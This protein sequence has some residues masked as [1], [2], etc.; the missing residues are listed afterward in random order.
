MV[1][2]QPN[3]SQEEAVAALE[4]EWFVHMKTLNPSNYKTLQQRPEQRF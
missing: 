2:V 4:A 1:F 3:M